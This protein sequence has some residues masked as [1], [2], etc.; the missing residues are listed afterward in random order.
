LRRE[1]RR[2]KTR[3]QNCGVGTETVRTREKGAQI[4]SFSRRIW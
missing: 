4:T 2:K 1:P 3:H